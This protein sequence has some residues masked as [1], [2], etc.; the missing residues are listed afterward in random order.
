MQQ[1]KRAG[2]LRLFTKTFIH[3]NY[4]Q[5]LL[6]HGRSFPAARYISYHSFLL[7]LTSVAFAASRT[8]VDFVVPITAELLRVAENP[9][10]GNSHRS[11]HLFRSNSV[12]HSVQFPIIIRSKKSSLKISILKGRPRANRDLFHTAV[13]ST[14]PPSRMIPLSHCISM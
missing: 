1:N 4:A 2:S 9:G 8:R 7:N 3:N 10:K 13:F 6:Y 12:E 14:P 5:K 11:D